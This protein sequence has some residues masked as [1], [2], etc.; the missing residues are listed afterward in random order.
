MIK[1]LSESL[2]LIPAPLAAAP[3][4]RAQSYDFR[5]PR[6]FGQEQ[7]RLLNSVHETFARDLSVHLS[8]RLRTIVDL[9][10]ATLD[11]I[12]YAGFVEGSTPPSALYVAAAQGHTPRFLLE[13]DPRL[14]GFIVERLFG[15][16]AHGLGE[17]RALS[18]IEQGM[19]SKVTAH[20]L[21][22]LEAAWR[23]ATAVRFETV[24]FEADAA[25][26]Q[27][28]PRPEP[29]VLVGYEVTVYDQAAFLKLCYP[30][31]LIEPLLRNARPHAPSTPAAHPLPKA[32][33]E[34]YER[35]VRTVSVEMRAELGRAALPIRDLAR[36][37]PGDV[38]PLQQRVQAP[39]RIFVDQHCRFRAAPGKSGRRRALRIL[40]IYEPPRPRDDEHD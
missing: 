10:L 16:T 38:I 1:K 31:S 18:Q 36:L 7:M 9:R 2:Q 25:Y 30:C 34:E 5:Q 22:E 32:E 35:T 33:R 29:T 4:E 6:R 12:P 24:G 17:A 15:G 21:R 8:A 23:P 14:A 13:V 11:Q 20:A 39:I 3:E 28:M 26:A 27:V 37:Q 19:M 40:E